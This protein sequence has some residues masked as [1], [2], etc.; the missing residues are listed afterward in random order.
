MPYE[1]V[2]YKTRIIQAK[3][4]IESELPDEIARSNKFCEAV[5]HRWS[6]FQHQAEVFN[7]IVEKTETMPKMKD[8]VLKFLHLYRKGNRGKDM[9]KENKI[10]NFLFKHDY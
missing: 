9:Q 6:T 2:G 7:N 5:F 10:L 3:K 1:K 8:F 4:Y